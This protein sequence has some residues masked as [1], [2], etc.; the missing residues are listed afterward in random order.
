MFSFLMQSDQPN[1]Y[2]FKPPNGQLKFLMFLYHAFQSHHQLHKP[3]NY[4]LYQLGFLPLHPNYTWVLR[5]YSVDNISYLDQLY[6]HFLK[7]DNVNLNF[8]QLLLQGLIHF[9][10][11]PYYY[12]F[13]RLQPNVGGYQLDYYSNFNSLEPH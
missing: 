13:Y 7:A 9:Q 10:F 12:K 2:L 4:S 1:S 5:N 8:D 11:K 6:Q 3:A